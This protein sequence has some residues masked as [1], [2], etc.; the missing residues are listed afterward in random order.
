M[1]SDPATALASPGAALGPRGE[2]AFLIN[3]ALTGA[4]ADFRKNAAVPITAETI[5][6]D[7]TA[8]HAAG[9]AIG[10]FH[11]RD[12]EGRP[13]NDA[14]RYAAIFERMR[15]ASETAD[16]ILCASTSGRHGQTL[17][18]RSAVLDLPA[19][20]RPDMASLTLGSLDFVT[21]ASV[22]DHETVRRLAE[23]MARAGVKPEFE[24][25]D[26]GMAVSIRRLVEEGLATPPFYVNVLLGNPSSAQVDA[27]HVGAL[28]AALPPGAIVA[29]A[30]I[31]RYQLQANVLALAT[32]DGA[33]VGLEDNLWLDRARTPATNPALVERLAGIAAV[34]QRPLLDAAALRRR[35]GLPPRS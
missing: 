18:Q 11:V 31:G 3:V 24:V 5:T 7:A 21:G 13:V 25:F 10:H 15:G 9:A 8:C 17:D 22:N 1:P 14:A 2:G 23:R 28:L 4:V 16:M 29:L 6:A 26:L 27:L 32:A 33:R 20:V 12:D 35:L 34:M 19:D 30:G